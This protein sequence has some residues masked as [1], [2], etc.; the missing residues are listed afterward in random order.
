MEDGQT[1]KDLEDETVYLDTIR[2]FAFGRYQDG[3]RVECNIRGQGWCV[4]NIS[5]VRE[6][7]T[8]D[9]KCK[10]LGASGMQVPVVR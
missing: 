4:G 8:Y 7:G 6:D 5:R 1:I 3:D 2:P 10:T 9:I